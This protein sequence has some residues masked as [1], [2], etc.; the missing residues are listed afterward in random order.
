MWGKGPIVLTMKHQLDSF[1]MLGFLQ[2]AIILN[3]WK[4][5]VYKSL[6]YMKPSFHD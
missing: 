1:H 5:K 6:I 2:Y 4:L 3:S